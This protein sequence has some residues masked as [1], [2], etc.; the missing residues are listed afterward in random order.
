MAGQK[1][2]SVSVSSLAPNPFLRRILLA[3]LI[4]VGL[5]S[6]ARAQSNAFD[7]AGPS[8]RASVTHAGVTLPLSQ[9]PNLSAGDRVRIAAE[10]PAEQG[11]RYIMVLAFL[12]GATNPPPKDWLHEAETWKRKGAAIDAVVPKGAEQ[13]IVLLVPDT[14]GA[15]DAVRSAVRG[16]PGAFV[17]ASQEL[18]QAMLDR[19]RLEAFLAQVRR[20]EVMDPAGAAE[21][22]AQLAQSLAVKVD[23]NCLL[24]Q[25]DT[26]AACLAQGR[27][28][29]VLADAQTKSIAQ[30]LA[31][32]PADL[33]FRLSATPQG[34]YGYYSPY[35]GVVRDLARILGAFQS[36]QLQFIPALS[37]QHGV[38]TQLLLNTP[39]S[40][41]KPHSVL[42]AALPTV[43]PPA[44]PPLRSQA[45]G[46]LCAGRPG[47]VLPVAGAPLVYATD[48]A[49][50]MVLRVRTEDGRTLEFPVRA[51]AAKGGYVLAETGVSGAALDPV[52]EGTLHGLWGF[53]PFDGP[54]FRLA[55]AAGREWKVADAASLVVGR[56]AP[57]TLEGGAAGC[58]TDV[59]VER[60]GTTRRAS[61]SAAGDGGLALKVPLTDAKPGPVTLLVRSHGVDQPQRLQMQAYAEVSKA[62]GFRLHAGDREGVLTGSR[63]DQVAA[64][65]ID[66]ATFRPGM[67]GRARSADSL[68][69]TSD[70]ADL[71]AG[72]KRRA[73]IR[74]KDGRTIALDV[75][76]ASPRPAA[77]IVSTSV[78]RVGPA[79]PVPVML[80]GE[81]VPHDARLTFS[82]RAEGATR[83]SPGDKAEVAGADDTAAASVPLR[84]QD[85]QVAIAE[86]TPGATLGASAYGPLR[87]RVVQGDVAGD[88]K[89]LATAVRLPTLTGLACSGERS[90]CVLSGSGLFLVR[91]IAAGD[92]RVAVPDGFTGST[93]EVPRPAAGRLQF[94]L[95]D[96]PGATA[97]SAVPN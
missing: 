4:A 76:V 84:L 53:Q 62:T 34:G 42:V 38:S 57:L 50:R 60:G 28:A 96:A 46:R 68:T 41:R 22:S 30:T 94:A 83:F 87:F 88:W 64:L 14:G 78:E 43:A 77:A 72:E 31:E 21:A 54:R 23:A 75:R 58:V 12:R 18:N 7:L 86:V 32:A 66:G 55:T 89:P 56:D 80:E 16:R 67:L 51:D 20:R 71:R 81:F 25:P 82:L 35:I 45:E 15:V 17:R 27:N 61:W 13:A 37:V 52:T 40:F 73:Q 74:L 19:A 5:A 92:E 3:C 36:A 26:Q 44:P 29:Q 65:E 49:R 79:A 69:M 2:R 97:T 9:V 39:P 59:S 1:V 47:L 24:R 63:L 91:S 95:R 70:A 48:Y 33:A 93:I 90:R 8:L 6:P 85:A 10:L 11:A